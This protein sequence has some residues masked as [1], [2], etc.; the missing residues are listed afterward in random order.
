MIEWLK[1]HWIGGM[2][3][4]IGGVGGFLAGQVFPVYFQYA[5]T[6]RSEVSALID[7]V[8]AKGN[9]L[10]KDLPPLMAIAGDKG[11]TA[12]AF[13]VSLN[14]KMLDLFQTLEALG[15]ELPESEP[16]RREYV[17]AMLVLRVEA[18]KLTGSQT[19]SNFIEAASSFKKARTDYE[20]RL[21]ELEPS[22]FEAALRSL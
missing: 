19:A 12:D 21:D 16:E 20:S 15:A 1:K 6:Q 3:L 7:S 22:L 4:V 2:L 13:V 14:S 17:N 11:G 10:E 18:S 8:A 9:D 5:E